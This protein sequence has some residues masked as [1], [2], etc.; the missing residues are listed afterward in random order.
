[1]SAAK[2]QELAN[3]EWRKA[4][5]HRP[6]DNKG[7]ALGDEL[8]LRLLLCRPLKVDRTTQHLGGLVAAL[9]A[10]SLVACAVI[11]NLSGVSDAKE[12]QQIGLPA[13]ATI[14]QIWDTGMTVNNDPVIGLRVEVTPDGRSPY[15]ATIKKALISRLDVPQF[16]P[17]RVIP[18]RVDPN[19]PQHVAIDFYAYK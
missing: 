18:V 2:A 16:Q 4:L 1:M 9:L 14:L 19:D 13:R 5:S 12:L 15:I 3:A 8:E 7:R 6:N 17:E 11:D 10:V